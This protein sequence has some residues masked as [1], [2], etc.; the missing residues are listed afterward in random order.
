MIVVHDLEVL[1]PLFTQYFFRLK[2]SPFSR[3]AEK[4]EPDAIQIGAVAA[5]LKRKKKVLFDTPALSNLSFCLVKARCIIKR[6]KN[7]FL[8]G[9]LYTSTI[10]AT[11]S[12]S[13]HRLD[14]HT[15]TV[16]VVRKP[17]PSR[18]SA[19]NSRSSVAR[20]KA[21]RWMSDQEAGVDELLLAFS[22]IPITAVATI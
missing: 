10:H 13:R 7:E 16:A 20:K 19:R 5:S 9:L 22:P 15:Q 21:M 6:L 8:I 3:K 1:R 18:P 14:C 17:T 11:A 12:S 4:T 2:N